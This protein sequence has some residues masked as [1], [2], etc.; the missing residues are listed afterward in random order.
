MLDCPVLHNLFHAPR[1]VVFHKLRRWWGWLSAHVTPEVLA[2]RNG[3]Y[4]VKV[5]H[6]CWEVRTICQATNAGCHLKQQYAQPGC[7]LAY[8][9]GFEV[10]VGIGYWHI[11]TKC[12]V[13]GMC[14]C[15]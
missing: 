4:M 8:A 5:V 2:Q 7:E 10:Q 15:S 11:G 12:N 9:N 6:A 1:K 13:N 14:R 3:E